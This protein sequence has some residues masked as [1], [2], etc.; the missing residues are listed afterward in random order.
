MMEALNLLFTIYLVRWF[1]N[2]CGV[3]QK[4]LKQL[5]L[6]KRMYTNNQRFYNEVCDVLMRF[7]DNSYGLPKDY[8]YAEEKEIRI[9][10]IVSQRIQKCSMS[11]GVS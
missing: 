7:T 11:V 4:R 8:L 6:D 3:V 9:Q 10:D 2:Y 1:E 5:E